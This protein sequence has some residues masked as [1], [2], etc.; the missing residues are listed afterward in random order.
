MPPIDRSPFHLLRRLRRTVALWVALSLLP[1]AIGAQAFGMA[2]GTGSVV[3]M[4]GETMDSVSMESAPVVVTH[5]SARSEHP[6]HSI[7]R[8]DGRPVIPSA[9]EPP[10]SGDVADHPAVGGGECADGHCPL[11]QLL[12]VGAI[13]LPEGRPLHRHPRGT[14]TPLPNFIPE[15]HDEPPRG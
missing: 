4:G 3:A 13:P 11:C 14:E 6:C 15:R 7:A 2:P 12:V 9:G 5:H 1:L 10:I 8:M